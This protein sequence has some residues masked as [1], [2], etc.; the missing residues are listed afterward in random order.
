MMNGREPLAIRARGLGKRY[1]LGEQ[2]RYRSLREALTE[3]ARRPFGRATGRATSSGEI[4][5]LRDVSFDVP[6]GAV[7]GVIGRNGAGKSTLLKVLSRITEPTEGR[8]EIR[9]R[10]GSLLEVGTGF[11]QELTG[12]ENIYLNGA[13][14]GMRKSEIDRKFDEIVAFA[15][16]ERFL[17][18]P[19]KRYS[20]GMFVRLA[21]GVAAHLDPEILLVD[22]VL[23]V[24]DAG[25][26]RKCLGKMSDVAKE[27]RTIL[28]VSHNMAAIQALCPEAMLL[29]QGELV[30]RGPSN[31]VVAEYL[32]RTDRAFE[33]ATNE[34]GM[35]PRGHG[36]RAI[37]QEGVLNG[38]ILAG[39]HAFLAGADLHFRFIVR[40]PELMRGCTVGVHFDD[41]VGVRVYAA[42]SRWRLRPVELSRG[43]HVFECHIRD[44]PLVPG[45]YYLSI[46]FSSQDEQVDWLERVARVELARTDV[47]GTG[48]LPQT[49]QGYF[50]TQADWE[51]TP[52][53]AHV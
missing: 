42:N 36:F 48:E 4:W 15:E 11:H 32:Q 14:L 45:R 47:Y 46:G 28:F 25:F 22:E 37:L 34:L 44:L 1:R 26:Q 10:V 53:R 31:E 9:G 21:F 39:D 20:S 17:D 16:V 19:V 49:G 7:V 2:Q 41:E 30:A 27:G 12:R 38:E 6:A 51:I 18:T 23:A 13:I 43:E 24:G 35:L 33:T 29:E 8:V 50:L 40:L 3:A 5:S 52:A